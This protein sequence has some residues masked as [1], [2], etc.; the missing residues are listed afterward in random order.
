MTATQQKARPSVGTVERSSKAPQP[1]IVWPER[2][3]AE[4]RSEREVAR[5]LRILDQ[6]KPGGST[7]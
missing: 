6:L 7:R 1:A 4:T 5:V 2:N 3:P